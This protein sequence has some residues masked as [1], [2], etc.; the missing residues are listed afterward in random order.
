MTLPVRISI[1][2]N[3][4]AGKSLLLERFATVSGVL[5]RAEPVERWRNYEGISIHLV[6]SDLI[7]LFNLTFSGTNWLEKMYQDVHAHSFHFQSLVTHT[8]TEREVNVQAEL[9]DKGKENVTHLVFERG[10]QR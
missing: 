7:L 10:F 8:M 6:C 2:G 5:T 9:L 3:I 4:G 1:E